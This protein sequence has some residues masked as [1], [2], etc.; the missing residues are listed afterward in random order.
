MSFNSAPEQFEGNVEPTELGEGGFDRSVDIPK[1]AALEHLASQLG[2]E[3]PEGI[4]PEDIE[5]IS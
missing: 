4:R 2:G 3:L 1:E 5:F